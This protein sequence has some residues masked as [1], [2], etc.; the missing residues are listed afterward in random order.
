M[1]WAKMFERH[2]SAETDNK[3]FLVYCAD[4]RNG[5]IGTRDDDRFYGVYKWNDN[6]KAWRDFPTNTVALSWCPIERPEGV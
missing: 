1:N 3:D 2:P 4:V 6:K 5:M